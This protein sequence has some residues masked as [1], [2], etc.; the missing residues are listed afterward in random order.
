MSYNI[1][2]DGLATSEAFPYASRGSLSFLYRSARIMMEIQAADADIICLQ[3]AN[4]MGFYQP[5]LEE[6]GYTV[7]YVSIF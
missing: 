4:Q 7:E 3:G 6:A 2:A 5:R 1:L